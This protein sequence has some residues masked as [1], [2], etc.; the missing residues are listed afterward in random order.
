MITKIAKMFFY[1]VA[2]IVVILVIY[3]AINLAMY[4]RI[5]VPFVDTSDEIAKT[6]VKRNELI[7]KNYIICEWV[8]TTGYNYRLIQDEKG[9]RTNELCMVEGQNPENE[10]NYDFLIA[11]N[12]YV[13]Y[14]VEKKP[15]SF[16]GEISVKYVVEGWDVLYP[17]KRDS[18]FIISPKNI[19]E[20]D[21][22]A[23][24]TEAD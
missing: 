7:G 19:F 14:V 22:L 1:M 11:H 5:V 16:D 2:V 15:Y 24:E 18:L 10:V 4:H 12:K 3:L 20:G 13:L 8:R 6:A 21:L 17:V 9:R 23:K